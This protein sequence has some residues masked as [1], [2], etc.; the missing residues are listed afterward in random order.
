ML[1]RA[2]L[3]QCLQRQGTS[4]LPGIKGRKPKRQRFKGYRISFFPTEFTEVQTAKCKL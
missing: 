1:S 2:A 3:H 4:L